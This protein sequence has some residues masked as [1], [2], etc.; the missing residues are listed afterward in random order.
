MAGQLRVLLAD[1][2]TGV[3]RY[4]QHLLEKDFEI[5]AAL[6]NGNLVLQQVTTLN[7][8]L[9]VLDISMGDPNGLE[10]ARELGA[11]KCRSKIIFLSV[12]QEFEF[13]QAAF[14]VGASG[15]VFKARLRTDL[16]AA[17]DSVLHG[18]IFIPKSDDSME[19]TASSI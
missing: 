12:H 3:L 8:D 1:D 18:K 15:Y 17:I 2:N 6:C 5:V 10:I 9:I 4:V 11:S 14:D 16:P 19:A 7:P 13:I